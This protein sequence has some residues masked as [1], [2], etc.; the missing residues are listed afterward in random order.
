MVE[1]GDEEDGAGGAAED[2]LGGAAEEE[3]AEGAV[4]EGAHDDGVD[5][6]AVGL[7]ED[8]IGGGALEEEG[9]GVDAGGSQV[10]GEGFQ[11]AVFGMELACDGVADAFGTG[12]VADEVRVWGSDVYD[13]KAC[14][15][16]LGPDAGFA[17]DGGGGMGQVEGGEQ[18]HWGPP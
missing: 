2:F 16:A 18:F 10:F 5:A 7:A 13:P 14:G 8:G 6:E 1:R 12:F 4:G 9:D 17:E 15:E 3:F 11:L